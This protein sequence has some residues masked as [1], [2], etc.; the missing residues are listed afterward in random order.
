MVVLWRDGDRPSFGLSTATE[1]RIQ[2][3][4]RVIDEAT[5]QPGLLATRHYRVSETRLC[6]SCLS[7]RR[8]FLLWP[9]TLTRIPGPTS[10]LLQR[11]EDVATTRTHTHP[12]YTTTLSSALASLCYSRTEPRKAFSLSVSLPSEGYQL[13]RELTVSEPRERR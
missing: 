13:G 2:T 6:L 11:D 8:S 7:L 4:H 5:G 3:E 10:S 1:A 9:A 12:R